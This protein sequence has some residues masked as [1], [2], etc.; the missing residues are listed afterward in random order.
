M[1]LFI[2]QQVVL[3]TWNGEI[4]GVVTRVSNRLIMSA[5]THS[6]LSLSRLARVFLVT[7][8]GSWL[9]SMDWRNWR[10]SNSGSSSREQKAQRLTQHTPFPVPFYY[11]TLCDSCSCIVYIILLHTVCS[12]HVNS[13][14]PPLM[15]VMFGMTFRWRVRIFWWVCF[16]TLYIFIQRICFS[17]TPIFE[18]W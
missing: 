2:S 9:N 10:W 13:C 12:S 17:L 14:V 18:I 3:V 7:P 4:T 15:N 11:P 5:Y 6:L 8:L 16:L 1:F